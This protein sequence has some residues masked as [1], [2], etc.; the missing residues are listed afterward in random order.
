MNPC[1]S[2]RVPQTV[3]MDLRIGQRVVK[4]GSDTTLLALKH[5]QQLQHQLLLASLHH[6]Q[7]GQLAHQHVR[8][9]GTPGGTHARFRS[10][11]VGTGRFRELILPPKHVA[12]GASSALR[13]DWLCPSS[14]LWQKSNPGT[15][16]PGEFL[17][18]PELESLGCVL[19]SL[20]TSLM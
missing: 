19:A 1:T 9:R 14:R 16:F 3:P 8:V 12:R 10:S 13:G 20:E 4:P 18:L 5:T 17:L 15:A 7:V 2:P 6:Q 11:W